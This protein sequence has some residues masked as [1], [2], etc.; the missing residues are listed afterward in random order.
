MLDRIVEQQRALLLANV[1]F[2][3]ELPDFQLLGEILAV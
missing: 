2:N 1:D 3:F